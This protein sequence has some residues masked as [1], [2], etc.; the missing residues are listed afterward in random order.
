MWTNSIV[1]PNRQ[2]EDTQ[3]SRTQSKE[4]TRDKQ[5]NLTIDG[6]DLYSILKGDIPKRRRIPTRTRTPLCLETGIFFLVFQ[7][8]KYTP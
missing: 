7:V 3:T 5:E 1:T 2:S 8:E 6:C 4:H